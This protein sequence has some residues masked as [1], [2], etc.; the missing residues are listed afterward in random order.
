[1]AIDA[2]T[3]EKTAKGM[4]ARRARNMPADPSSGNGPPILPLAPS[5]SSS[6]GWI[7]WPASFSSGGLGTVTFTNAVPAIEPVPQPE[8]VTPTGWTPPAWLPYLVAVLTVF[9][10]AAVA[11]LQ[12]I[13]PGMTTLQIAVIGAGALLTALAGLQG[14]MGRS[15]AHAAQM[16]Q[17]RHAHLERLAR[18]SGGKLG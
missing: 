4:V 16:Q 12:Q 7:W 14:L 9:A 5:T 17:E 10:A 3:E 13:H 1:M 2:E 11:A 15:Q 6:D 18:I 8:P